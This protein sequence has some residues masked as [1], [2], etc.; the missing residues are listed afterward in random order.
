[1][2]TGNINRHIGIVLALVF[3]VLYF[4]NTQTGTFG[5][6][7]LVLGGV[8]LASQP[9]KFLSLIYIN[10]VKYLYCKKRIITFNVKTSI[11]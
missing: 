3:G 8:F 5:V 9:G 2:K 4:T 11:R 1:M 10:R 7:L 6:I